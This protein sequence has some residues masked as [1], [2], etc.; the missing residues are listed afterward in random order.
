MSMMHEHQ[1]LAFCLSDQ[2]PK[3]ALQGT[4]PCVTAP[5]SWLRLSPTAQRSRQPGESPDPGR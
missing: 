3:Q 5:A 1:I 4:A 2:W